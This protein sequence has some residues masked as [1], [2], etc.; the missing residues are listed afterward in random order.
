MLPAGPIAG[1]RGDR[2]AG[3]DDV[4]ARLRRAIGKL[5]CLAAA[6]QPVGV[7]IKTLG[8]DVPVVRV[9]DLLDG[10]GPIADL[11]DLG[12]VHRFVYRFLAGESHLLATPTLLGIVS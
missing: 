6:V 4:S 1:G 7:A 5:A 12:F 10:V 9:V 11:V 2:S 8:R 3:D